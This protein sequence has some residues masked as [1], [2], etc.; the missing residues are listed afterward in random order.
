MDWFCDFRPVNLKNCYI[1]VMRFSPSL[2][3]FSMR[4]FILP[5]ILVSGRFRNNGGESGTERFKMGK[6]SK[7]RV[8]GYYSSVL[9][10]HR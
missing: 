9:P 3:S 10:S 4:W 1:F 2:V 5:F 8:C 6:G 7:S